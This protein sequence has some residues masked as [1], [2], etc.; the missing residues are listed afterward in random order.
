MTA[1]AFARGLEGA[2][3]PAWRIPL[4]HLAAAAAV[5]LALFHRDAADMAAIWWS[6]SNFGHVLFVPP[7]V[8]WLVWQRRHALAEMAPRNWWPAL[9]LV[10]A[11]GF[12]WLLG[13]AA[14]VALARHLGLGLMLQGAVVT[15]LG[16]HIARALAFPLAYALFLVPFGD[17]LV[18]PLQMLTAEMCMA[19]LHLFGVPATMDGVLIRIPNGYFEVA[20]ACA[21]ANFVLAMAAYA[22]LA[23]HLCF[24]GWG[25]RLGFLAFA[26]AMPVIA[27]G[28]RAFATIW[29]AWLTDVNAAAG[30][31]HVVYGWFFFAL[32][33]ALVM[34]AAWPFMDRAPGAVDIDTTIP[35]ARATLRPVIALGLVIAMAA[36]PFAWSRVTATQSATVGHIDLPSVTGWQRTSQIGEPWVPHYAGADIRA[37]G[38]YV[39]VAGGRV[40]L[41]VAAYAR[42]EEGRELV[43]FGQGAIGPGSAWIWTSAAPAI[44]DA[45]T[46]RITGPGG[47]VREVATFY[48]IGGLTTG[49]ETR[50]KVET[51]RARLLGS[52]PL[53]VAVTVSSTDRAA[54]ERFL[55]DLGPIEGIL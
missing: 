14:G 45:R 15:L 24:R 32:V 46:E 36:L 52:D 13:E 6:D 27:N 37:M 1:L 5:I 9:A 20:E 41:A 21:G 4:A 29:V 34:A 30:F 12:G 38:S 48:R 18:Q 50:V 54:L 49:S 7:I 51:M 3:A 28:V 22:T 25:R 39:D 35:P 53:A 33:M 2:I 40:E 10:A 16:L 47:V 44:P 43:G 23:A 26:L 19:L 55:R 31:D 42:Q 17:F 11:G 8:G